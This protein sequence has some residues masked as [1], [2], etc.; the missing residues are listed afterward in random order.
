MLVHSQNYI[1]ILECAR[2]YDLIVVTHAGGDDGFPSVPMK[3]PPERL[4]RVL[5]KVPYEKFVLGHY[6]GHLVWDEVETLLTDYNVYFDTAYTFS[7]IDPEVFK[8]ILSKIGADKVLFATDSPWRDIKVEAELFRSY[9]LGE[10]IERKIFR[11]N[12]VSLLGL[13]K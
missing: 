1:K 8:R 12:A 5:E 3:C 4:R 2:E 10:E 9:G 11:D 6:G 13:G 7:D